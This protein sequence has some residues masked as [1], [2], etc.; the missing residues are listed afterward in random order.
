MPWIRRDSNLAIQHRRGAGFRGSGTTHKMR[1]AWVSLPGTISET[2]CLSGL[3]GF[4][5]LGGG[6]WDT[7]SGIV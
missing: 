2:L 4:F 1:L 3:P 7:S 6:G 5:F